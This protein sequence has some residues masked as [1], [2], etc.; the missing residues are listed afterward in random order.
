MNNPEVVTSL[1][2]AGFA[3]TVNFIISQIF[4]IPEAT[5]FVAFMGCFFGLMARPGVEIPPGTKA[6][7]KLVGKNCAMLIF[8]TMMVSWIVPLF[9]YLLPDIAQKT[10]AAILGF[11]TMFM[12]SK[13]NLESTVT[14]FKTLIKNLISRW[15]DWVGGKF[16]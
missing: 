3:A 7:I 11:V 15:F 5:I 1:A 4:D 10:I 9:T 8:I 2:A 14:F 12:Y 6:T 16:K 13:Q